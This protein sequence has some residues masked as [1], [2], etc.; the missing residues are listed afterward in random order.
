MRLVNHHYDMNKVNL[1]F[2]LGGVLLFG[3][4]IW[5]IYD[6]YAKPYKDYQRTFYEVYTTQLKLEKSEV[7]GEDQQRQ[8][9]ELRGEL[10][11]LRARLQRRGSTVDRLTGEIRRLEQVTLEQ[12]DKRVKLINSRLEPVEFRYTKAKARAES[13]EHA[14]VPNSLRRRYRELK[15]QYDRAV[16]RRGVL[17]D[18]VAMK[19]QEKEE[20]LAARRELEKKIGELTRQRDV[21]ESTIQRVSDR[22]INRVL[23]APL[24]NFIRPRVEVKQFQVS[25]VYLDYNFDRIPRRD[26][27]MSCHM[28]IDKPS[29]RLNEDGEFRNEN[30]REAFRQL[31]PDEE[32]RA[33]Y[34]RIF[35]A[36][37]RFDLI[38]PTSARYPFSE[39]G[40]TGC[41]LGDGR[42]LE[43]TR[44]AHT[45][46]DEAE[47][48]RWEK[49]Y[50]WHPREYWEEP[51]LK[52]AFYEAGFRRFYPRGT[53]VDIP[54]A[55]KLNRGRNLWR[56]YG[57]NGCHA[58]E[59][60]NYQRK[61]GFSLEHV[62]AKLEPAW[63][64]RW[65]EKPT[66]FDTT[67]RMPQVFHRSNLD[68][69][70]DR[71]RSTV[72]ID[73]ITTYLFEQS[74]P[75]ELMDPPSERGDLARGR[76]LTRELGCFGCHS[77]V[78]EGITYND[79]AP[80]LSSVGSKVDRRWLFTWLRDPA[81]IW[82]ETHMPSM[83]LTRDEAHDVTDYLMSRTAE[84]WSAEAFPTQLGGD[85]PLVD[86]RLD[87]MALRFLGMTRGPLESAR[88]LESIKENASGSGEAARRRAV[89]LYVGQQAV[90][91]FGCASCHAIPGHEGP[92]RIGAELTEEA[93]KSLHKFAFNN[94]HIPHTRQDFIMTKLK[95]PGIY[96][97]GLTKGYLEKLRMPKFNLTREEREAITTHVMSQR[98]DDRTDPSKRFDVSPAQ[99]FAYEGR[100]LVD[101][102]NCQGCHTLD[103]ESPLTDY[104]RD[105]YRQRLEAGA[106]FRLGNNTSPSPR[107]LAQAHV[108][109]SLT[110][111]GLR[112]NED[113]LFEF[114]KEP[115]GPGGRDRIRTWQH[116]RMP[117]FQFTDEEASTL[118][119]GLVYEGWG[120]LPPRVS[121]EAR[122]TTPESVRVG[123]A[124]FNR[125]CANCHVA[126]G[127][128][129]VHTPQM[130]P[131]LAYVGDKFHH[132]GFL[133]WIERPSEAF[134][135]P[136]S[137]L[138][139]HQGMI[140]GTTRARRPRCGPCGTTCSAC[141]GNGA[142]KVQ[143][144]SRCCVPRLDTP[145][146]V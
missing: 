20:A 25:G 59:G 36:H 69:P 117:N 4:W 45:P 19:K 53:H 63:V 96:D 109:P 7:W 141:L 132:Q 136:S 93:T 112:L 107:Q 102:Y 16:R 103:E 124:I 143:R 92:N 105:Y 23:D 39:Y 127:P 130:T 80:D 128:R 88:E 110:N 140:P 65:V 78:E 115:V 34:R 24:I 48:K 131:N 142:G 74:R 64:R 52:S 38:G 73:A 101:A 104:L 61:I 22:P 83:K 108:P 97:R 81:S 44:A 14:E 113:W 133:R 79:Q 99:K 116:V 94:V 62:G 15:R 111:V 134:V 126:G 120:R 114:L 121:A 118:S 75:V 10:R 67:T 9:N 135:P 60:M 6:D 86:H 55:P 58:L 46:D 8:L 87:S 95:Q 71:A 66:D 125:V 139:R 70:G 123:E 1:A 85:T 54:D 145:P 90:D 42:A 28:G 43:F 13:H 76:R 2:F 12:A 40:C 68:E 122:R 72:V 17:Q 32:S 51:M 3:T 98:A 57:C 82:P 49:R 31:F 89:K 50:G 37:P 30:T 137:T 35:Q 144:S 47:R 84:D 106:S 27:C 5:A 77:M 41:H 119:Q 56:Q 91:Y 11:E 146:S 18:R 21:L 26:Y 138:Y 29:F 100:K 33:R 129:T